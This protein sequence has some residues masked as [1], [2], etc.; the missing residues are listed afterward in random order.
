MLPSTPAPL[1]DECCIFIP[2]FGGDIFYVTSSG[3]NT[4]DGHSPD[5]AV[6]TIGHAVSLAT[7]GDAINV[8]QGTYDEAIDLNLTGLELWLEIGVILQN[9]TPGTVLTVSG[10][11]CRVRGDAR[12]DPSA[13]QK[14]VDV[15]GNFVYL[16]GLRVNANSLGTIGFD[17]QGD[18][19][20]LDFCRC[21]DPTI[22][23]FK[24]QG[25]KTRIDGCCTGGNQTATIGFWVTNSCD[26]A[27]IDDCGSQGHATAGFQFDAGCTNIM[28]RNSQSG[29]GDGHFVDNADNTF[30]GI[31]DK[32]SREWHEHTYPV[33]DG[34]GTAGD[35]IVMQ[36]QINDETGATNVKD[37]YGDVAQII[38]VN[39]IASD[40]F[41]HGI[42]FFATT[43]ADD[44]RFLF[45]RVEYD[46]S[47]S[48]NGG[49]NW[50]EGATVLT[51]TDAAEAALF[52]VGDSVWVRSPN[53]Q[54]D[55]EIVEVTDVTGAVITIARNTESSG[56]T[57]LHWDHTTNDGGNEQMFLCW[58]D[59]ARL[60]H[61]GIDFSAS[62]A[63]DFFTSR[64]SNAR[65]M[66]IGDGLI[67]RMINGTDGNNSQCS[68]T[69]I[70]SD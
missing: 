7:A 38:P 41:L 70:W 37:Y 62:G 50:D 9:T 51:V 25:D 31:D 60:H 34:E 13:G 15:T 30:L 67:G 39:S 26:K 54:P 32:D 17:I 20:N 11:F 12:I 22:V 6:A 55:G 66:H 10:S 21:S 36:S 64:L 24:V 63:R 43:A 2:K 45:Y 44:Q 57:G 1:P 4:N 18:G 52:E 68:V 61:I 46:V 56:R 29:G 8:S 27:R 59:E 53:Y 48:R 16:E 49:N 5:D 42:N 47:A 69:A 33:P 19:C 14:G 35:A 40:W 3:D 58:R 65:R 28:V 23:A